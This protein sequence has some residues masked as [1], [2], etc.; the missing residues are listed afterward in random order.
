MSILI[1]G[2]EMPTSCRDCRF[3]SGQVNTDYGVCAWCDVDGKARDAYTKQDCPLVHVPPHGRLGDLDELYSHLEGWYQTHERAF[4]EFEAIYIRAML[5][6]VK[7]D[8]TIIPA[9]DG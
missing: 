3:C 1:K 7:E 4:T 9:E 2:M 8:P 5:A 6:G